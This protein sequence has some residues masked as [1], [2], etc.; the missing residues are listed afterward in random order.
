MNGH[1]RMVEVLLVLRELGEGEAVV[2]VR[3]GV[4]PVEAVAV[5]GAVEEEHHPWE[6]EAVL[7]VLGSKVEV[8]AAARPGWN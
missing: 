3:L 8:E 5:V 6:P 7:G 4:H 1:L 2:G